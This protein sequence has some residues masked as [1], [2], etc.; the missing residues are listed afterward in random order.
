MP[1]ALY[2]AWQLTTSV[3]P[4]S[5]IDQLETGRPRAELARL[6]PARSFPHPP[7]HARSA[8]RPPGTVC[9]FYRSGR[10]VLDQV[11]LYRLCWDG[12]TL[13]AKDTLPADRP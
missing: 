6:L 11:D 9:G 1:A 3:L 8:P 10:D 2:M 7:D 12:D 13:V 5:R 4:P